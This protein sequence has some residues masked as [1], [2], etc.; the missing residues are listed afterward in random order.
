M[1]LNENSQQLFLSFSDANIREQLIFGQDYDSAAY[2]AG[3]IRLFKNPSYQMVK[4]LLE[5]GYL[6]PEEKQNDAGFYAL[7]CFIEDYR[8]K[9]RTFIMTGDNGYLPE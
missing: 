6:S 8:K 1:H 9:Y 5:R 7:V 3:G 2:A 4:E